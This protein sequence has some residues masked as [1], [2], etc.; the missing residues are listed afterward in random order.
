MVSSPMAAAVKQLGTSGGV[1]SP[2]APAERNSE[3]AGG[4]PVP[5]VVL[6]RL[7]ALEAEDERVDADELLP[8]IM[9]I[10]VTHRWQPTT[11]TAY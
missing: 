4:E 8:V 10:R 5:D 7:Q 9:H 3:P 1:S 2:E 11:S 6:V